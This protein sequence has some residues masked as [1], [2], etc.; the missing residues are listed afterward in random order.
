MEGIDALR[1]QAKAYV[2][3]K[4]DAIIKYMSDNNRLNTTESTCHAPWYGWDAKYHQMFPKIADE[5]RSRGCTVTSKVNFEV[6]D[7]YISVNP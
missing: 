6:T 1:E 4:A 3:E 7:W 5:L 2:K